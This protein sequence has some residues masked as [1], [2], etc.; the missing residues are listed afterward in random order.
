MGFSPGSLAGFYG[1]HSHSCRQ[2]GTFPT[3]ASWLFPRRW[4]SGDV[5][6][7]FCQKG[8]EKD[9][10]KPILFRAEHWP[11]LCRQHHWGYNRSEKAR[12]GGFWALFSSGSAKYRTPSSFIIARQCLSSIRWNLEAWPVEKFIAY[13]QLCKIKGSY[14]KRKFK[15]NS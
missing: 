4:Y 6:S 14:E 10:L 13:S 11:D 9:F 8:K 15:I 3:D 5:I 1:E 12:G 7:P 2:P